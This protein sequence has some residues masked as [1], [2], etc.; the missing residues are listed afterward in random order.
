MNG[1]GGL[2]AAS[3]FF[4]FAV[5]VL[6]VGKYYQY[7]LGFLRVA[8]FLSAAVVL[9]KRRSDPMP[10]PPYFLL[11][12]GFCVLAFGHAFSSVYVWVSIQHALNILL[13]TFL[14]FHV[15]SLCGEGRSSPAP[16]L[17]PVLAALS[18]VEIAV[19]VSQRMGGGG[20][21]PHGT[22]SN[23]M[24]LSE[25]LAVTALFFASRFLREW[26]EPGS[27]KFAWGGGALLLLAAA[28][29]LTSSRG[30]VVS[31]VPALVVLAVAHFGLARGA[32]AF[33]LFLPVL[34]AAG[35]I[36]VSRFIAPD[37][38]HY[39]RLVFWR[40]ALR[41]F[42]SEPFGVGL[43]G[44]KYHWF[45][46]QE[47]FP[48]AF[49]HYAKYPVTPHNEYLEVLTG[50]GFPGFLLFAAVL[51][52]P[53]WYA[54]RGWKGVPEDRRWTAAA[55][56]SGLVLSGSNALFNFNLHEFG[57]VFTDVLLL[58][59]LLGSLP[60]SAMGKRVAI[61]PLLLKAAAA[62]AFL[63]GLLSLSFLAGAL[64]LGRGE[65]LLRESRFD[66]AEGA[67]RAASRLDPLRATVPDVMSALYFRRYIAAEGKMDPSAGEYLLESI[68]WQGKAME[69]CP[70]EQGFPLRR[71]N[72]YMEKYLRSA[73]RRDLEA[74]LEMT[75]EVLRVN[76][77][78][79][80]GMWVR[81]H[82]QL[83]LG[84]A[85][86]A[87]R[88]LEHAVSVEP[89]FCRGY[90]KLAGLAIGGDSRAAADF[91]AKAARCR[92]V[93]KRR[94]QE[95]GERWLAEEPVGGTRQGAGP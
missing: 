54:A 31:L 25:F 59:V 72:L 77:Y 36:S 21:R 76:P 67:L 6:A 24:F 41:V 64:F 63:M 16:L 89:N 46:T 87:A 78:L 29:S 30:V 23:P 73:D 90:A 33:L 82:A 84:R 13:A 34:L 70:L 26:R 22:F 95:D 18:V 57:I 92:E 1:R 19:A 79:V 14:L 20:L 68:R 91:D 39:G 44:Y 52:L 32:K 88:T 38:Y 75:G 28:L 58:G 40:S 61:R 50:L 43:G 65:A 37:V 48:E 47:P 10:V 8:V 4:L 56:V 9:W 49:R 42:V 51:L 7:G 55:A 27:G 74:A 71:A 5:S 83:G 35:W 69:L 11:L 94:A 80:E 17:L 62:F 15:V 12:A 2:R 3:L 81:A 86:D 93:A 60:D 45:T 85:A 53:L 66:A